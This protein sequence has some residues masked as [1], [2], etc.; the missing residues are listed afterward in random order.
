MW[1]SS[2]SIIEKVLQGTVYK[3]MIQERRELKE[4]ML[5]ERLAGLS[6]KHLSEKYQISL[7]M[8]RYYTRLPRARLYPG[9]KRESTM[10][11]VPQ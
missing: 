3:H 11:K 8:V 5:K 7:H 4:Q 9:A 6:C 2:K 10:S 1:N